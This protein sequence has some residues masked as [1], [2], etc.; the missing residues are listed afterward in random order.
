M[1]NGEKHERQ[2]LIY[3]TDLDK[4]FYFF[5]VNCLTIPVSVVSGERSFSKLKLIKSYLKSIMS[6]QRLNG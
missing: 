5:V 1:S 4:V 3:S 6:Q 2:W